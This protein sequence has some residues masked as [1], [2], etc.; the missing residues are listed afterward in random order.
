MYRSKTTIKDILEFFSETSVPSSLQTTTPKENG[1][2]E[3][4]GGVDPSRPWFYNGLSRSTSLADR[5][6]HGKNLQS[7]YEDGPAP[8]SFNREAIEEEAEDDDE[9]R[10]STHHSPSASSSNTHNASTS[11][12]SRAR[13][14]TTFRDMQDKI[15]DLNGKVTSLSGRV[16]TLKQRAQEDSMKRRSLQSLRTPSPLNNAEQDYSNVPLATEQNRG[17]GLGLLDFPQASQGEPLGEIENKVARP[18]IVA[19][20]EPA[21]QIDDMKRSPGKDSAGEFLQT[22]EQ[23]S[24]VPTTMETGVEQVEE[25]RGLPNEEGVDLTQTVRTDE[26]VPQEQGLSDNA[27]PEKSDPTSP[28][29]VEDSLYDPEKIPRDRRLPPRRPCRRF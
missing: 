20:P 22:E 6:K 4:D 5:Y 18:G 10:A 1:P 25:E 29:E 14:A 19:S 9:Q 23:N 13:S 11:G 16:T 7:L 3:G 28:A 27:T 26:Q 2:V 24:A 21:A 12:L 15:K 8:E 17:T